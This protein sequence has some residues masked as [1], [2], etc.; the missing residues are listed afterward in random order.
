MIVFGNHSGWTNVCGSPIV[1]ALAMST[2]G[3]YVYDT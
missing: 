2:G 3:A 1:I